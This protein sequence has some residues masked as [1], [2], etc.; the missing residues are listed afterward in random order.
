[1]SDVTE[2]LNAIEQGKP[3]AA[4]ELLPLVYDE[5]RRL[6]AQKLAQETPGQTLEPTALVHEAYVRLTGNDGGQ[7]WNGRVH[8]CAA[9]AEAMRRILIEQARRKRRLRHGGGRKRLAMDEVEVA[10]PAGSEDPVDLA[11]AL[12]RLAQ[13][14]KDA[15]EVIKLRSLAG[16]SVAE[17][18]AVLGISVRTVK[19]N[20]AY[21]RAWLYQH[22]HGECEAQSQGRAKEKE[23]DEE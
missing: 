13:Q 11:V 9:A 18:A 17:V 21:A 6:A 1:M 12:E 20:S 3:R 7:H 5:L 15:A 23:Q 14:D 10:A 22:L 8:F 19:R 16:L 4:E 2:I